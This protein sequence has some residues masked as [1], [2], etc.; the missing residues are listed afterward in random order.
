MPPPDPEPTVGPE[1]SGPGSETAIG[2]EHRGA[3]G[4]VTVEQ[5]AITPESPTA[6]NV[7]IQPT[8]ESAPDRSKRARNAPSH[9]HNYICYTAK[10]IDPSPTALTL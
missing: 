6:E 1:V 7:D 5:P 10:R 9:L 8:I 3:A 4:P 2:V